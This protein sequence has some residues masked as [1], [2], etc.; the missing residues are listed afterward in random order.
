VKILTRKHEDRSPPRREEF[1]KILNL[2]LLSTRANKGLS[3]HYLPGKSIA[4]SSLL[5]II[6][7]AII[8]KENGK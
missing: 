7:V 4:V 2:P 3:I 5:S 1:N 8:L 6:S